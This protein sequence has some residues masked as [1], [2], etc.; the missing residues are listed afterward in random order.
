MAKK[1]AA[2][3][4]SIKA[5]FRTDRGILL[6]CM[7][8]SLTFW[9]IVKLSEEFRSQIT[10]DLEFNFPSNLALSETPPETVEVIL[11]GQGWDLLGRTFSSREAVIFNL[12]EENELFINTTQLK[13]K[14]QNRQSDKV[15]VL[16][17]RPDF[18]RL[19]LEPRVKKKIPVRLESTIG[20]ADQYKLAGQVTIWPDS[21]IADGPASAVEDLTEWATN[22]AALAD[23]RETTTLTVPLM[24]PGNQQ[25]TLSPSEISATIPVEPFTEK[26]VFVP[27]SVLNATDSLRIYPEQ[28][29]VSVAVGLSIY[30][31]VVRESFEAT[32][33]LGDF[34]TAS[35]SNSVSVE[36]ICRHPGVESFMYSPRSV[37]FFLIDEE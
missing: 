17:T 3:K 2:N 36:V 11:E 27:V 15:R 37:E 13:D 33:N 34:N 29:R 8:V 20:F 14:V 25:V 24:P 6:V 4:E 1:K 21:I 16:D 19:N 30:D 18:L 7:M 31:E 22:L 28:V 9:L 35:G 10:F 26:I 23:V 12:Q 5:F 32:V